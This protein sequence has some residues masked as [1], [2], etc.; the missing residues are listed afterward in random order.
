MLYQGRDICEVV[1]G[2]WVCHTCQQHMRS[3]VGQLWWT[4]G[5][6]HLSQISGPDDGHV[7]EARVIS[8]RFD[9]GEM[10]IHV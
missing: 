1:V 4:H 5:C 10:A 7:L 3:G 8:S 9:F 6:S 2:N